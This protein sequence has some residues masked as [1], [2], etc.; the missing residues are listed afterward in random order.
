[1]HLGATVESIIF[2]V[3]ATFITTVQVWGIFC[4]NPNSENQIAKLLGAHYS[5]CYNFIHY[6]VKV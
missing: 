2:T 6:E 4:L 3:Y 5:V 1:M